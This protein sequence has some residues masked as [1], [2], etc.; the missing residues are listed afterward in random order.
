M[1]VKLYFNPIIISLALELAFVALHFID[2]ENKHAIVQALCQFHHFIVPAM[3]TLVGLYAVFKQRRPGMRL[4]NGKYV[5][6]GTYYGMPSGDV[7]MAATL[8]C[9]AFEN[10]HRVFGVLLPLAVAFSRVVVGYHSVEQVVVGALFGV[11][12]YEM[13]KLLNENGFVIVNWILALLLPLIVFFDHNCD[14]VEKYDFDNLQVWVVIDIGYLTFDI[15]YCAPECLYGQR[16][17]ARLT[18]AAMLTFFSHVLSYKMCEKGFSITLFVKHLL[19][20]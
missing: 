13:S 10:E 16:S 19:H 18:A 4:V 5:P 14:C 17:G 7:L 3:V 6:F 2:I 1:T 8:G 9:L 15:L 11:G 12:N 20:L